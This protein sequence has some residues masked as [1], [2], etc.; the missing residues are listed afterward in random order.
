[1]YTDLLT[2]PLADLFNNILNGEELPPS[3]SSA[4]I[5]VIPKAGW[6]ILDLKSYRPISLLNSDYK[7]FTAVLTRRLNNIISQYIHPDQTGFIPNRDITDNIRRTL[8][9]IDFS[10]RHAILSLDIEKV[11]D[12]V[13]PIYIHTLLQHMGFGPKFT[14]AVSAIYAHS[15]ASVRINGMDSP[16]IAISRGTR[17]GCPLSLL[18][19]ALA[20][21]P[22][23]ESLRNSIIFKGIMAGAQQ[24]KLCL[25]ADDI[26][27]YITDLHKS[28]PE[29]DYLLSRFYCV[30]G[31]K[32]NKDKS[33][34]YPITIDIAQQQQLA[35]T[36]PYIW[37]TDSWKY[38]GVTIPVEFK[39]FSKC[40]LEATHTKVQ[41]LLKAWNDKVLSWF[42]R[43][44][45]IKMMIFPKFLFLFRTAPLSVT[46]TFIK[47]LAT[48]TY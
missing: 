38:L 12:R 26:A 47:S 3:W 41:E 2:G 7:I 48:D 15:S 23:A 16:P 8:D 36:Y 24:H 40:N 39:N 21:E 6:D 22:L 44:T 5:V 20:I 4:S 34:L 30:S 11:F 37:V 35:A 10:K 1:M 19:F 14:L 9:L 43:I 29:I 17:Q 46:P 31:L 27:L 13:E 42:E 18:L 25:F 45:I 33:L 28:L 32:I